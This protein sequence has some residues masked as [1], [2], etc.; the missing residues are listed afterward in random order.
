MSLALSEIEEFEHN[1][2]LLYDEDDLNALADSIRERG[3]IDEISVFHIKKGDRYI[4]SDGHRTRRAMEMVYGKEHKVEVM[5]RKEFD[6]YDDQCKKELLEIGF[7]TSTLKKN[8]SVYEE[9]KGVK[10]YI[11]FL[12]QTQPDQGPF[13]L[14]QKRVYEK[15]GF[16]KSNAMNLADMMAR[17]PEALW[18]SF[19]TEG[20]SKNL[21]K[22][23]TQLM[24]TAEETGE[25]AVIQ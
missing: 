13:L 3:P 14:S 19:E 21:L 16:K 7:V 25:P 22:S 12:E 9:L 18:N 23:L 15:L 6:E 1:P 4:I 8:L 24:K 20:V 17:V 11:A 2:R 10:Q 5:V